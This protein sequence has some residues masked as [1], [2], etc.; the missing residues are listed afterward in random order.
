MLMLDC[1]L[2]L[3]FWWLNVWLLKELLLATCA[4]CAAGEADWSPPTIE[5]LFDLNICSC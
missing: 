4:A 1:L 5:R 2:I 3:G